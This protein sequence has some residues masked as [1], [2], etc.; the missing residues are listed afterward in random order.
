MPAEQMRACENKLKILDKTKTQLRMWRRQTN[1]KLWI[2]TT[3]RRQTCT[4]RPKEMRPCSAVS[5]TPRR[6]FKSRTREMIR[7]VATLTTS[8]PTVCQ[9]SWVPYR[10]RRARSSAVVPSTH[11]R[12]SA[13]RPRTQWLRTLIFRTTVSHSSRCRTPRPWKPTWINPNLIY[14]IN[15]TDKKCKG[16]LELAIPKDQTVRY[17]HNPRMRPCQ[18]CSRKSS[19]AA[20]TD[21]RPTGHTRVL[22]SPKGSRSCRKTVSRSRSSSHT[23]TNNPI[24][25]HKVKVYL[26]TAKI[27]RDVPPATE[28]QTFI[29]AQNLNS[30]ARMHQ[31][32]R[33]RTWT[34][35]GK[36]SNLKEKR[37]KRART[38]LATWKLS[39]MNSRIVAKYTW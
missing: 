21:P 24:P 18:P 14:K 17:N 35:W 1:S 25:D 33:R 9:Q 28:A 2:T 26:W 34:S 3:T 30:Q 20:W 22:S 36:Q 12:S 5:T 4:S 37:W 31:L 6:T 23:K 27:S 38:L 8:R 7:M 19:L 32:W 39:E 11:H 29:F 13:T 15:C 10:A 16:H